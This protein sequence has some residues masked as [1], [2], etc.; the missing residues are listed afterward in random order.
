MKPIAERAAAETTFSRQFSVSVNFLL[1]KFNSFQY[2]PCTSINHLR[3]LQIDKVEN[4][5]VSSGSLVHGRSPSAGYGA[6]PARGLPEGGP[7]GA[8][9]DAEAGCRADRHGV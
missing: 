3:G 9:A 1:H 5:R 4:R 8:R 2:A 7:A 6:F